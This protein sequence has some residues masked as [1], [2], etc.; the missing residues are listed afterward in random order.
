MRSVPHRV[1]CLLGLDDGVFPR[2]GSPT[3]TTCSPATR[4]PASATCAA[5]TASCC[6]TRS[7]AATESL[8]ITY[9]GA[10]EHTGQPRPP[11][12]P[13]GELLDALDRTTESPRCATRGRASTRSSPSTAST[14]SPA[15]RHPDGP[16]TFDPTALVAAAPRPGTRPPQPAFLAGPLA[17]PAEPT[18]S[19]WPTCWRSSATRSRVL[20]VAGR[21]PAVGGRRRLRRDAGRDRQPGEV[22]GRR[23]DA[24][25]HAGRHPPRRGA[26]AGVAA[27]RA[28]AGRLGWRT[29]DRDP[30][31][32]DGSWR[33]A[34]SPTVRWRPR[35]STWTST[36]AVAAGSPARSPASTPTGW[37]RSATPGSTPSSCSA[38]GCSCSRCPPTTTTT[39]GPRWSSAG[40]PAAPTP[41]PGCSRRSAQAP[42]ALLADLVAVYDAGRQ[43]PLP[44]P[45]KASFAWVS[46]RQA[47]DNPVAAAEQRWLSRRYDGENA[48]PRAGP[49]LGHH[50]PLA[51]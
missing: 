31:A 5:R 11:A 13:L 23:P 32:G 48:A 28:P 51:R 25:R 43:E 45:L 33:S 44:L 40:R 39:T 30:R 16:F 22:V 8:V 29:G 26:P 24:A 47:G 4:S 38:P 46:A 36:S 49:G 50:A 35:R 27:R 7:C 34:P 42:G 20:P 37:S 3:A 21:H 6:S 18:T 9:T 1:V 14:S 41:P 17:P 19:R 10:N 12:V 2:S 15:A